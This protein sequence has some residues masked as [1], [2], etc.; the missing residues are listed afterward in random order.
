MPPEAS[1]PVATVPAGFQL[2]P[3]D[4]YHRRHRTFPAKGLAEKIV[5]KLQDVIEAAI[6]HC[7]VHGDPPIYDSKHFP[8]V[9]QIEADWKKVRAELD[10]VMKYRDAIPSFQDIVKEVGMIQGDD[11]WKTFFLKGVGM[12]CQE[13]ARHCPETMKV[14]DMIPGCTTGFFSILSPRKHI[15]E[16]RGPWA[17][18]LRMHLG[19]LVPEPRHQCRIRIA[20]EVY[21]WEE[22]KAVIFDDTYNHEVWNDT[23]GYR[24]VLFVDFARPLRFPFNLINHWIMNLAALAPFLREA[25]GK[26]KASEK[27]FWA[28]FGK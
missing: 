8:W 10:A 1:S 16:H 25:K 11:Q 12:D 2:K 27:K 5:N 15:P 7:S 13:N 23:N 21:A 18:V 20:N 17:G 26:Q 3:I 6:A 28:L 22:G 4:A 24:V 9:T 14:L 19:L